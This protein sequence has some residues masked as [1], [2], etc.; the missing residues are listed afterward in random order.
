MSAIG[1]PGCV[2]SGV[3]AELEAR[4]GG[5]TLR[6]TSLA[7]RATAFAV[8]ELGVALDLGRLTP[9]L[10]DQPVVLLSHAHMDH[11]SGILAYLNLRARFH[12]DAPTRL[13]CPAAV[14]GPLRQALAIMPG[15]ESVRRRLD[16]DRAITG[17]AP[18]EDVAVPGGV[19]TAFAVDHP[20]PTLGW[21][22]AAGTGE[23]P[24]VVFAADGSTAPFVER[25]EL[26]DARVAIVE[27]T[28]LEKNRRVAA[29]LSG[30]AH[31]ADWIEL[32]PRLVCDHLVLSHLPPLGPA[33]VRRLTRPLADAFPGALV[34]WCRG[35][36]RSGR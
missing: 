22:L 28:F 5:V 33:A 3:P 30:H 35:S 2:A 25:P 13:A 6:G 21:R 10:A 27:C 26:L 16:L 7:A 15:M 24:L 23:R 4:L 14:A 8:P 29:R 18:G 36:V 12:P 9:T 20:V 11:V 1:F 34:A 19:A 32:A 31:V 17:V